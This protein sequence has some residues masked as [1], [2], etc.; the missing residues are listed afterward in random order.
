MGIASKTNEFW[1]WAMGVG[2]WQGVPELEARI[3]TPPVIRGAVRKPRNVHDAS[4]I[5]TGISVSTDRS[6]G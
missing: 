2:D 3:V 5:T 4:K 6:Q 1:R